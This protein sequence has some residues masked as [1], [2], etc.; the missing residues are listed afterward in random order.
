MSPM[1]FIMRKTLKN[2]IKGVFKKPI[3]FIGYLFIALFVVTMLIASFAMPS[4]LIRSGSSDLYIGIITI[5]FLFMYYTTLKLGVD[6]GST[7]FRAA[8]VNLAFTAPIKP[9]HILLYGFIKQLG[10]TVLFLFFA[11][12]QIPNLKNNFEM[13]PYGT[14]MILL[15]TI[16]Y[17]LSYPLISMVLY[18]WATKKDGRK[19]LLK[20]SFDVLAL[21]IAVLVLLSLARTRNITE[22]LGDVFNNQIAKYFPVIGWTSSIAIASVKGFTTE[23]WV[24]LIGMLSLIL[25]AAVTLYNMNLD[26]Y[27][28]VLESTEYFEAARK[29]KKEGRNMTFGVKVK[30]RVKQKLSGT[31]ASTIFYKQLLEPK[32]AMYFLTDHR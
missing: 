2:L 23:F 25:G 20:R 27:E 26:Y 13:E 28:D 24:G 30:D 32:T 14:W 19:K 8:D 18:S 10:G 12:C 11:L 9:N 22:T 4:G 31:G 17:T 5:V 6:K 7:Y 21:A 3:L 29:A 15:A 16:M 1:L